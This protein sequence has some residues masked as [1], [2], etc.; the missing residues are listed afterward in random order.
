MRPKYTVPG[1]TSQILRRKQTA[2]ERAPVHAV[3][4]T[5]Y[6][7][8]RRKLLGLLGGNLALG[9]SGCG[10][11]HPFAKPEIGEMGRFAAERDEVPFLKPVRS[12]RTLTQGIFCVDVHAHFFNASDVT[13][14]GYL[15][16]P[17]AHKIGGS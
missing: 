14:K 13:V 16:G 1:E 17:V 15:E 5:P 12:S 4:E 11:M 7:G 3:P 9:L 6:L 8:R 2:A 10:C